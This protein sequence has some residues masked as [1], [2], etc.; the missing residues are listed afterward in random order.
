MAPF[1]EHRT[2]SRISCRIP[3]EFMPWKSHRPCSAIIYN[4]SDD[5]AYI[6]TR[7]E[8]DP[9]ENVLIHLMRKMPDE[10]ANRC[11]EKAPA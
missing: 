10:I 11:P 8:I 7:S 1:R 9:G 3:L 5:G 4:V 2:H 6:E